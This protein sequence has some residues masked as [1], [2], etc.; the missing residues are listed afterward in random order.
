MFDLIKQQVPLLLELEKDLKVT[1]QPSGEKNWGIEGDEDQEKCPFCSHHGC[2]KVHS[3][4][5]DHAS[6][7]YKCFSC[8]NAGDVISW[9]AHI[10][11]IE[12][13]DAAKELAK[14]YNISIPSNF[15]PIQQVFT[16]AAEYYHNCLLEVCDTPLATLGGKTPL[17]YQTQVRRRKEGILSSEK[18]GFSDGNLMAYLESL[19]IDG[20][21]IKAS[22]LMASKGNRDFLPAGCFIYP[23]FVKGQA[24]HFTFK[25]PTKRLSFQLHKSK[26][27]NGYEFYGQDSF[28]KHSVVLLV[29][30]ENDRLA[31]LEADPEKSAVLAAIG[32]LSGDQL[33]W[34]KENGKGKTLVTLF[35]PDAAGDEYR[36]KIQGIKPAFR[37]LLHVLPPDGLDI[38][39]LLVR[40][41]SLTEIISKNIVKVIPKPSTKPSDQI[42]AWI[43]PTLPPVA[44]GEK[45]YAIEGVPIVRSLPEEESNAIVLMEEIKKE[46][47]PRVEVEVVSPPYI[48]PTELAIMEQDPDQ[49]SHLDAFVEQDG[50]AVIQHR[51]CYY[52]RTYVEGKEKVT[53]LTNFTLSLSGI[54]VKEGRDQS[55]NVTL[56]RHREVVLR[57]N[58]GYLSEPFLVD[59]ESKVSSRNF[60]ILVAKVMDG[61]WMGA[62]G[63]LNGMWNLVYAQSTERVV[64]MPRRVGR[65]PAL[66]AWIFKNVLITGSGRTITP[67]DRGV[68]WVN[69]KSQGI[70]PEVISDSEFMDGI[71]KLDYSLTPEETGEMTKEAVHHLGRNLASQGDALTALGWTW[72]SVYSDEI[73]AA[74]SGMGM[75]LLWGIGGE[76]KSTIT[77]WLAAIY[78]VDD[79]MAGGS[80]NQLQKSTVGFLRKAEYY[81][82]LPMRLDELRDNDESRSLTG[83]IRSWYDR[84]PRNIASGNG[85]VKTQQIRSTLIVSGED[86]PSDP[87]TLSRFVTI[88]IP[89]NTD[90]RRETVR[91]Y[92]WF[93]SNRFLLS[94]IGFR[95]ILE[96][97]QTSAEEVIQGIR[98]LDK[99]M[100]SLGCSKRMSKIW[101][102]AGY[103]G[104]RLAEAYCPDFDYIGYL[105]DKCT[106]E[107]TQQTSDSTMLQFWEMVEAMQA[108]E[109]TRITPMHLKTKGKFLH[110]WWNAL[111]LEVQAD[112]R[113]PRPFGKNAVLNA[114][115]EEPWYVS[116]HL[117]INMGLG[118]DCRK[119][120]VTIDMTKAPDVI[121]R[122]GR[123]L[124]DGD[125]G[126]DDTPETVAELENV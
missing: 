36:E 8:G 23:H 102:A 118:G 82:S 121:K 28:A 112:A 77:K 52:K 55:G 106:Q 53:R 84:E 81:A 124:E 22:G 41:D 10:K 18:I 101:A 66:K 95:W 25:D 61:E 75:L 113:G 26:S 83:M 90:G 2:F 32:T 122:V 24:S 114:I 63:D 65:N 27:L 68:F 67:D 93:E 37:N 46:G 44:P 12:M 6:S 19:G 33:K 116:N 59:S 97:T 43:A 92:D 111:F 50:C 4:E 47:V 62:D 21:V 48:P 104:T 74:N 3:V 86:L 73:F 45:P 58:D 126:G 107:Q 54:F 103:F 123:Y 29:E 38:D 79:E 69:G 91:S 89:K 117:K 17:Q 88:R 56:D 72:S 110:I 16:L 78:G 51:G 85:G 76:G 108:R 20:E 119:T 49:E 11:G 1:F 98:D 14:E 40:G 94:N 96:S 100:V 105:V 9:R 99:K 125:S 80:V 57:R 87:A 13:K 70:R 60:R 30:G 71:P 39:E 15:N 35:D 31:V 109:N 64:R 5:G 120:V 42:P 115:K 7:F 34:L